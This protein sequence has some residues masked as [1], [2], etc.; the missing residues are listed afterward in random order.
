MTAPSVTTYN[1]QTTLRDVIKYYA[2]RPSFSSL[3]LHHN[4]DLGYTSS[5]GLRKTRAHLITLNR[6][7]D[8]QGDTQCPVL[9]VKG[10]HSEVRDK[11]RSLQTEKF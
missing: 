2:A 11:Y 3:R 4:L 1:T 5:L 7:T 9:K 6:D 10:D 8:I